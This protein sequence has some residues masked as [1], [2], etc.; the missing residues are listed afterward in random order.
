MSVAVTPNPSSAL[1]SR[2]EAAKSVVLEQRQCLHENLGRVKSDWKQDGSRVTAI[3]HAISQNILGALARLFPE[4]QGFSEE[5]LA[6]DP[7]DVTSRFVWVLDPIDGTNNF[8]MGLAQCAISLAL[9]EDGQPV[10]G[11]IYDASRRCLMHGGPGLRM[12][13][14]ERSVM[15]LDERLGPKS[16]VGFHSPHEFG[17][18]VGHGEELVGRYKI[19]ALGSSALHLA[20][21]A[22]GLFDG[23]V[24]HNVKLWDIAAG[25]ALIRGAGGDVAFIANAPLPLRRFDLDMPRTFYIGGSTAVRTE[26]TAVLGRLPQ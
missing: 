17:K 11:V 15:V 21:V 20:Y 24:D 18:Y 13:D 4:D 5:L 16:V 6:E 8:A 23:V 3:D 22:A 14:D 26:L 25:I 10:Y 1:L 7:L 12:W 19:R 2:V 9:L